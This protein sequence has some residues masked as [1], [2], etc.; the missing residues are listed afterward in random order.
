MTQ[1]ELGTRFTYHAPDKEKA[2]LHQDVR[3]QCFIM[4]QWLNGRLPECREKSI[5]MTHLEEVMMW[6]NAAIARID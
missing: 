4:A 3:L 1:D 2:E 5:V 6:S